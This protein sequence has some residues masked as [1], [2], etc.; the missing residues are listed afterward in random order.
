MDRV[1]PAMVDRAAD[2]GARSQARIYAQADDIDGVTWVETPEAPGTLLDV[3]ITGVIDDHD[4]SAEV[5]R[6]ASR[7]TESPAPVRRA[8]PMAPQASAYTYGK[9]WPA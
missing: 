6:V 2:A 5:V 3:R 7:V 4:F 9:P 1:V 8:L